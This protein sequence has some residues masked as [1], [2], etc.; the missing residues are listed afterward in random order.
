MRKNK[1]RILHVAQAAGGV[2]R[3]IRMLLKYLD[4][5]KFENILVCS[6]DFH[7]EDYRGL[8]DSFEQVEM[9]RAI[10]GN[11][12]KAIKEV[13]TL[14]KK[15]NPDIVYAHSSKAG[16]IARIAD[17]GLKNHCVYNP[18]GWAFNMRC[19]AKKKAIY[20]C[21]KYIQ[22]CVKSIYKCSKYSIECI[23]VDDGSSDG[24]G[25]LCDE[26]EKE[27]ETVIVVHK[28]NGGVSSARNC[29]IEK[30]CGRYITFV[31][32][33]DY[34][35]NIEEMFLT[36]DKDLYTF[37]M[38][39]LEGNKKKQ[40][41]FSHKTIQEDSDMSFMDSLLGL[42]SGAYNNLD[43][44]V[45][46]W[47]LPCFFVTVVLFNAL[48][49]LGGKKIVYAVT[50]LMSLIYVLIPMP[51]LLWGINRVFKYIGFYTLGVALAEQIKTEQVAERKIA[52]G[53]MAIILVVLN[54]ILAY[55]GWTRG[56][57]W[58]ATAVF[59]VAGVGLIAMLINK[60]CLLQ[61]LGRI[62]LMVL[63][64]HGP[65]YRIVVK[66]VSIPLCMSTNAV[67]ENFLLAMVVVVITMAICSTAYEVVVRLAPW[68]VGKKKV[69]EN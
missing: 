47:F 8:V 15:Y 12:L 22:D 35:D 37:G 28:Q 2:D 54:F 64:I 48:V 23:L 45:H 39:T 50:A 68:M 41:E 16:A 63:C 11:D 19:S 69:K 9:I 34:L 60:N 5:E 6:Q 46:L 43:F 44:N 1:I 51:E 36:T 3:Y 59:G 67:R 29:G 20:N 4:K 14:I 24:S 25:E 61:Y 26:I 42:L 52:S 58:F 7:E 66:I 65:V 57:M 38:Q 33:D 53:G 21:S 18:H 17:I 31:D 30:A 55:Y 13:R 10:G 40:I 62:S 49:N 27:Y 32:G 56:I